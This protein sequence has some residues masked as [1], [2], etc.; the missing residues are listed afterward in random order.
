MYDEKMRYSFK[1]FKKGGEKLKTILFIS[2]AVVLALS[3]GLIGCEGEGPGPEGPTPSDTIV[4]GA[5]RS[6]TGSLA[7]IHSSALGPISDAYD[8]LVNTI[9]DPAGI[10][11]DGT[12]FP[13]EFKFLNDGSQDATMVSHINT[14]IGDVADGTVHT[15][16]GPTSTH[17]IDVVAPITDAAG[18]VLMTAEG[19]ATSLMEPGYLDSWPYVFV[20]LSFSNWYEL[21]VLA[22]LLSEAGASTAYIYWQ[23]D[24]HGTEY[25]ASAGAAFPLAG[26]T[27]AGNSSI[28]DTTSPNYDS[29]IEKAQ[30]A[31]P[32]VVCCFCYPDEIAGLT[33]A[34]IGKDYNFDAWVTGPGANFGFWG[35]I[36]G[37]PI[38][39]PPSFGAQAEGVTCFAVAN[40]KTSPAME[41]LFN[42]FLA[43]PS[44][45]FPDAEICGTD[46][47]GHPL[48]W[49]A[50]EIWENAVKAVGT[51]DAG[52]GG[53][54]IDQDD[55]QA[56]LHGYS[57]EGTGV[58][59][60]LGTT[61][62]TMFPLEE[63]FM[64]PAVGSGGGI[65]AYECH[66]GE[67]GQ[68]Q[69]GYVEVVAPTNVIN[70][71]TNATVPLLDILPN[72]T[73]TTTTYTYPK[74]D[75]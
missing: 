66:T 37:C 9:R 2:L 33:G 51:V 25:L 8:L 62:Y 27:I 44:F 50:L 35:R 47:W 34:A 32:D 23:Y 7:T 18:V 63:Y 20:T 61:W 55:L 17:Q 19:G 58:E 48:Y 40:N 69:N 75:W 70:L 14:L 28:L 49:A 12:Y 56:E 41:G 26:L 67:I 15:I 3:I 71:A 57:S 54:L 5:S 24:D 72:Y 42:N 6:I 43:I 45:V 68:W 64:G 73:S 36:G 74:P 53:F 21:P 11:V 13:L 65:L 1:K 4:I 30:A 16:F 38:D 29:E 39:F 22:T 31:S 60:V 10:N 59:T 46:F 52:T